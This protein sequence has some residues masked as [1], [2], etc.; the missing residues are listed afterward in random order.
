[1]AWQ[2]TPTPEYV[3]DDQQALE[4]LRLLTRKVEED[5]GDLIG[6][7]TETHGKK[8]PFT[9]GSGKPL[10]WMSDTVIFWSLSCKLGDE[11]RRWCLQQQHF[12]M[13]AG[14]LE[15]PKA[16]FTAWN[17]KYDGHVSWNSGVNIWEANIV[18]GL[19]LS[20]LYD[21]NLMDHGL[22][23]CAE[24]WC[25]LKMTKY[26]DLFGDR[27]IHG[28]K[29]KEYVTSLL[30]LPLEKVSDYASYD[31]YAALRTA[32]FLRD[33]LQ[34]TQI[35]VNDASRTMWDH[36][37]EMEMDITKTLWRMERRGLPV[38]SE[39]LNAKIPEINEQI[40]EYLR[41]INRQAGWPVNVEAPAQLAQLFFGSPKDKDQRGLGLIPVKMTPGGKKGPQASTDRE[42]MDALKDA[43][44]DLAL[45]II[46]VRSLLKTRNTYLETL[47]DL[48]EYY[49]DHRIHPSFHQH[50]A[51]TGR[52]STSVPN[53]QNFC[54][55]SFQTM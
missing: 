42:V 9:V 16:W 55:G 32:E 22:K 20:H 14:L 25:G 28:D 48:A 34:K 47:R 6:F 8:L 7:D 4:L 11:Y 24:L 36:F 41:D 44:I 53:S 35:D 49:D 45:S 18:D 23:Y 38:N 5:P 12:Q 40:E 54:N 31:A 27:D 50:G 46:N 30:D 37:L 26:T 51:R 19:N 3:A 43:G 1:M 15:N 33:E 29:I 10:D 52:F 2:L 39:Y 13:F 21:E 17:A